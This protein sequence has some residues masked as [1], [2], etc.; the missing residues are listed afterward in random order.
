MGVLRAW[1][2]VGFSNFL[3]ICITLLSTPCQIG[4][5]QVSDRATA[6]SVHAS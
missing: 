6:M 2:A 4:V 1:M 5:T 3:V